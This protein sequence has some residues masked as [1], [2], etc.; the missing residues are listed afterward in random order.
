MEVLNQALS[1]WRIFPFKRSASLHLIVFS[2]LTVGIV[3]LPAHAQDSLAKFPTP[4]QVTADYPD[5]A[6]QYA[7]L[8]VLYNALNDDAPK[9]VSKDIYQKLFY[10]Q[11]S[12]NAIEGQQMQAGRQSPAYQQWAALR[13]KTLDDRAFAQSVLQK[14][15]IADLKAISRPVQPV[16]QPS[17]AINSTYPT[18]QFYQ[19]PV[20]PRHQLLMHLLPVALLSWV[21]MYWVAWLLANRSGIK[22]LMAHA[23]PL[24]T[25]PDLPPLPE[26]LRTIRLPGVRYYVKTFSGLVLDKQTSFYTT[27]STTTT[28]D[29]VTVVGNTVNVTPGQTISHRRTT[30]VDNLRI[31]TAHMR[32]ASWALTGQS[33]A[34]VFAGQVISAVARPIK[35]DFLEFVLAYNHNT[36]ELLRVDEGLDKAHASRGILA[37]F[38]Q[39]VATI[40]G[41]L[42]F[43]IVIGYFATSPPD[44]LT[45][46]F[47]IGG[48][49]FLLFCAFWSLT[50]AFFMVNWIKYKVRERRNQRLVAEY[51]PK[52]RQYFEQLTPMLEKKFGI[53]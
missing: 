49:V 52:F 46:D 9:P 33:G 35:D 11:A 38:A 26:A 20:T 47:G 12:Y 7:A 15:Q 28:P 27:V 5:Q 21:L 19:P 13:D 25:Y 41:T 42:G 37:W 4:L 22:S 29:T 39:P 14:Y 32:E 16:V 6:Q 17:L 3:P 48:L 18:T 53:Q 50:L 45:I 23:P 31:R 10:Y 40:I 51:G 34:N 24:E 8:N 36:G 2:L 44:L 1:T 43:V 30:R